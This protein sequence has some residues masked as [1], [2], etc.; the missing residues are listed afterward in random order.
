MYGNIRQ[1]AHLVVGA[2][3]GDQVCIC[4]GQSSYWITPCA[5]SPSFKT[6]FFKASEGATSDRWSVGMLACP[7][8]MYRVNVGLNLIR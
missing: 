5:P 1:S 7:S 2:E 6:Q 3:L 8:V 4:N